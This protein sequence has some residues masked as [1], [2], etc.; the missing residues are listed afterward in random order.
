MSLR[1]SPSP[2]SKE[3]YAL[4][5]TQNIFTKLIPKSAE[6][7]K[8]DGVGKFL[9]YRK[10]F[11]LAD[12]TIVR[13]NYDTLYSVAILD[14]IQDKGATNS[15]LK[16]LGTSNNNKR[17]KPSPTR[18]IID[19][20]PGVDD[21]MALLFALNC[22]ELEIEGLTI[23]MGNHNDTDLL[24][25]NACLALT[26]CGRADGG[27]KVVKGARKPIVGEYHGQSGIEVHGGNGLG[28]ISVPVEEINLSPLSHS[29][30]CA[31]QFMV[32]TCNNY[33]GEVTIITLGP[34]T[35]IAHALELDPQFQHN[36]NRI[37]MMG[38]ALH[39]RGNKAAAAEANVHNDPEAAKIVFASMPRILMAPLDVTCQVA[40][41]PLREQ[42]RTDIK[43]T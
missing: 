28:G 31:A 13:P 17:M 29:H 23:V 43:Y 16:S 24:A 40:L 21:M 39:G 22:D 12:K 2:F 3:N 1:G 7:T 8:T 30:S 27:I 6:G 5:E 42:V 9:H 36:V 38:G 35:N 33:P 34:Q 11:D 41:Q 10:P 15:H 37:A 18:V 25:Q 26:I 20:D 19:T 14:L 32:D 4:A